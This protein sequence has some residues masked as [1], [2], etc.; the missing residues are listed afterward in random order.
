MWY[1]KRTIISA[2]TGATGVVTKGLKKHLEDIP[3]NHSMVS[4]QQPAMLGTSHIVLEILQ[5]GIL[6]LSVGANF[7]SRAVSAEGGRGGL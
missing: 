7:G 4:L 5:S 6:S 3:R 2:I 1:T